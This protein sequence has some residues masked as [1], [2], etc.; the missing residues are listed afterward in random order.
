MEVSNQLILLGRA[1][2]YTR[3]D[4]KVATLDGREMT[5]GYHILPELT[6]WEE[7]Q[8]VILFR[9]EPIWELLMVPYPNHYD[10]ETYIIETL[11][12]KDLL[13]IKQR[14]GFYSVSLN[15]GTWETQQS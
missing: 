13:A 9:R 11:F 1:H 15:Y 2:Y 4:A 12:W 10:N 6:I 5:C 3:C 14:L 7:D 8:Y